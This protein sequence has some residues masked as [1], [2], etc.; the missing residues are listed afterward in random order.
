MSDYP[1]G[2]P[3]PQQNGYALQH[4]SPLMRTQMASGR[5]RQRRIFTSVPTMVSCSWLLTKPQAQA[6]EAWFRGG[7]TD[8]AEWFDVE[9]ESP[10]GLRPYTARFTGMYNGP[11]LTG[12]RYWE[13]SAE[14]ELRDRAVLAPEWGIYGLDLILGQDII[15]F[16]INR[17]W[18]E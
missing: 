4:V 13:I 9:I 17:E 12:G 1:A 15:D 8:G 16:A 3:R 14:L 11:V 6:F 5:A 18:P 10:I 7:I 2:L